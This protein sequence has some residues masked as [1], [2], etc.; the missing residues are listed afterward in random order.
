MA[1]TQ[2]KSYASSSR[3][4]KRYGNFNRAGRSGGGR[5]KP[6][7]Q[8]I[9]PSRFIR[10]AKPR[11]A[12]AYTPIH[13]FEDFEVDELI[14]NNLTMKGF[15]QPSPIQDQAIPVGLSGRDIVGI[16]DTGTGKTATFAIPVLN[17]LMHEPNSKALIVAPT[18]EL[19]QQIE[20]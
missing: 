18:R 12:V 14:K 7:K 9:D 20:D 4:Q 11:E 5:R 8:F 1:Y 16:A 2:K 3:P 15:V 17:R 6:Q 13:S 10:A 19:A